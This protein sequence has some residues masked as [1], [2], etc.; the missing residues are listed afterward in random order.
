[1]YQVVQG[2]QTLHWHQ[3]HVIMIAAAVQVIA[4]LRI[5]IEVAQ[6]EK[7]ALAMQ[8]PLPQ[9][10]PSGFTIAIPPTEAGSEADP[11]TS[12]TSASSADA[13]GRPGLR[14]RRSPLDPQDFMPD[15]AGGLATAPASYISMMQ[16]YRPGHMSDAD[17]SVGSYGSP[18]TAGLQQGAASPSA[19]QRPA[20]RGMPSSPFSVQLTPGQQVAPPP[21]S[22]AQVLLHVHVGLMYGAICMCYDIWRAMHIDKQCMRGHFAFVHLSQGGRFNTPNEGYRLPCSRPEGDGDQT[23]CCARNGPRSSWRA[24]ADLGPGA[25]PIV[26]SVAPALPLCGRCMALLIRTA[27]CS[28]H[29]S[30]YHD[31]D[32]RAQEVASCI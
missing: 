29:F 31:L 8:P 10:Q 3:V 19:A 28:L 21:A 13:G 30:H 15:G 2:V 25:W 23:R 24:V 32:I 27:R 4:E 6:F 12:V 17:R 5:L 9:R 26:L 16:P 14:R 11:A 18:G 1:M 7:K 20:G 22:A